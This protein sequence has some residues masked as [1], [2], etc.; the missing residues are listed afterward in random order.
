VGEVHARLVVVTPATVVA[1][2][3]PAGSPWYTVHEDPPEV[4]DGAVVPVMVSV[5]LVVVVVVV[6]EAP[7]PVIANRATEASTITSGRA[8]R[9]R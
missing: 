9:G 3:A 1:S 4:E 7:G 6:A 2:P 5:V 8:G